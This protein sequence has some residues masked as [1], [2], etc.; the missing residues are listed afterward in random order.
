M[1]QN[2]SKLGSIDVVPADIS[3]SVFYDRY[4]LANR[5]CVLDAQTTHTWKSRRCWVT[6]DG[7]PDYEYL[8]EHFGSAVAPV[9]DC[10]VKHYNSQ[11]KQDMTLTEYLSYWH[12]Y[13]EKGYPDNMD[14]LYLKDWHF[15]RVFPDYLAYETPAVFHS[16]WLNEFWSTRE[17]ASDD[18]K[19]V[20]MG[21]KGSWTPFHADVFRSYSWSAN[22]CGRKLW[23]LCPPGLEEELR[24]ESR[25]L[26]YD[27]RL[28]E[29]YRR[30][31]DKT[32]SGGQLLE[33]IQEAGQIIFVPSNWHHQVHNLEDTISINH[34]W[35]NGANIDAVLD[36]LFESLAEVEQE[37]EDCID[38]DGWH[39][40]C[41][42]ILQANHG[43]SFVEVYHLLHSIATRRMAALSGDPSQPK[44]T[45]D[46][47][48]FG[49]QL[50]IFDLRRLR[51]AIVRL[52]SLCEWQQ[53]DPAQFV[54]PPQR[55]IH[56]VANT[57]EKHSPEATLE[58]KLM[59]S[60]SGKQ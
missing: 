50:C 26:P 15:N 54:S 60:S 3:P 55:L 7:K 13:R 4:L 51:Q 24:E 2:D 10:N 17:D 39:D 22:V 33:V 5:P 30:S 56:D 57:I 40:Q 8:K 44:P 42:L 11:M 59:L 18:Y 1:Q 46:A 16:D 32:S 27:L 48:S 23:L 31:L 12:E 29:L 14:C 37:I 58:S 28:T 36:F 45:I 25:D 47:G 20:Y 6:P 49:R 35:F 53:L 38:M 52:T 34:N 41:Q 43:M 9:A 19:F 21:P